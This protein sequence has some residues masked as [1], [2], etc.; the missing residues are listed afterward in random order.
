M[1]TRSKSKPPESVALL[2]GLAQELNAPLRSLLLS[3]QKLLDTYKHKNF[4]YISYNDFKRMLATLEQINTKIKHCYE[5]TGRLSGLNRSKNGR[6]HSDINEAIEDI[7]GLLRQQ[8]SFQKI[9][10]HSRLAKRLPFRKR[11]QKGG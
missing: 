2:T 7:L 5:I 11:R 3:S 6:E 4:E 9:K 10:I 8:L 1:G